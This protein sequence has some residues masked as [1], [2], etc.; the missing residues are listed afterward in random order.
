MSAIDMK[1]IHRTAQFTCLTCEIE[2]ED[3]T[4]KRNSMQARIIIKM[5]VNSSNIYYGLRLGLSLARGEAEATP[6]LG[7]QVGGMLEHITASN[8]G[9]GTEF[10]INTQPGTPKDLAICT[11]KVPTPP[12]APFTSTFIPGRIFPASRMA[13]R[14]E[15]AAIGREAACSKVIVAGFLA[16]AWFSVSS[17]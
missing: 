15:M 7:F 14:A 13:C 12:D 5:N 4:V 1:P 9:F 10:N 3:R 17:T 2:R 6:E 11:A 16:S 8:F